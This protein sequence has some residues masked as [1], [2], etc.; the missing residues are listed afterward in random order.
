M[1]V[2]ILSL[3]TV[4]FLFAFI[5]S[6]TERIINK[7]KALIFFT[8]FVIFIIILWRTEDSSPEIQFKQKQEAFQKAEK[9]LN[10]FLKEHP[11]FS[12]E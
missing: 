12:L 3:I 1:I 10:G 4:A 9:D 7:E 8:L 11:E 6:L 5:F 2:Q